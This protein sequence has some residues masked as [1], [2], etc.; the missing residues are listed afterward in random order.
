M[1][2][3]QIVR[4]YQDRDPEAIEQTKQKYGSLFQTIAQRLLQS[5][6]EAEE[7]VNDTYLALWESI[8]PAAP[9]P[10]SAYAAKITR[11]LAMKRLEH[12]TAA[13]RST[14]ATLSFDE[15]SECLPSSD[16]LAQYMH[17]LDLRNALT[18]FLQAQDAESRCIFLRRYFFFDSVKE[19]ALRYGMSQSKVKSKLMRTRNKLKV[20][21]IQE[22]FYEER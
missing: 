20:H 5:H 4:L 21:L 6:E 15:L 1:E 11:N 19:I 17:S 3:A 18:R 13:K 8:P 2:D 9:S 14:E 7:C 16:D 10:L 12:L 22:G